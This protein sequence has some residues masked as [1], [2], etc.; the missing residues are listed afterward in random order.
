MKFGMIFK[1]KFGINFVEILHFE[2]FF[3]Q[4]TLLL[5]EKLPHFIK[6]KAKI[7]QK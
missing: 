3:A 1:L 4:K 2:E 6:F 7:N 5:K